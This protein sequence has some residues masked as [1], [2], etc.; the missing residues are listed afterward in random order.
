MNKRAEGGEGEKYISFWDFFVWT[1][2]GLGVVISVIIF[3]SSR[4][5]VRMDESKIL[6]A[7]IV[8]CLVDG[9]YIIEDL[10]FNIYETCKINQKIIEDKREF[11]FSV[12]IKNETGVVKEIKGG[13]GDL[14]MQC[15]LKTK[16]EQFA[17]CDKKSVYA[18]N[19]SNK[20]QKFLIE[21][22]AAS[23]QLGKRLR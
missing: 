12:L 18:V 8:D 2:V 9:G 15:N 14:E 19:S 21:V 11:Y 22:F 16:E 20:E 23:N 10:N 3:Y 4:I 13:Y 1:I 7:R 5:D 17:D 6:A